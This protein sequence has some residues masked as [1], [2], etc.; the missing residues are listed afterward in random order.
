[1]PRKASVFDHFSA[2]TPS[3][4]VGNCQAKCHHCQAVIAGSVQATSNF[5]RHLMRKHPT[6]FQRLD[7]PT[8]RSPAEAID[9]ERAST[10]SFLATVSRSPKWKACDHRQE[11][12]TRSIVSLIAE[13][14]LPL[15]FAES[16]KFVELMDKAESR[17]SVPSGRAL[18]KFVPQCAAKISSDMR[19]RLQHVESL[20]L[21]L[22]V[23]SSR[24]AHSFVAITG[25]FVLDYTLMGVMLGIRRKRGTYNMEDIFQMY[26]AT[27]SRYRLTGKVA[28]IITDNLNNLME[29]FSL[30]GWGHLQEEEYLQ[31]EADD[32]VFS[33]PPTNKLDFIPTHKT[34][35]YA[36]S[37]QLVVQDGLSA[38][39]DSFRDVISQASDL[40]IFCR[41]SG[42]LAECTEGM[43]ETQ[44]KRNVW[45][46]QLRLLR[47]VVSLPHETLIRFGAPV[48]FSSSDLKL[49]E[50]LCTI[51]E[52]FEEVFEKIQNVKAVTASFVL[53]CTKGL[54]TSL[55]ELE[56]TFNNKLV[57]N[58]QLS[59]EERLS[60]Y[61]EIEYFQLAAM[62]DPRFKADWCQEGKV[63]EMKNLL[64]TA[65]SAISS[66]FPAPPTSTC[67]QP[68][69]PPTKR[70][71]LFAFMSSR[72][73][74]QRPPSTNDS[75]TS[76]G[77]PAKAE[78]S[79]YFE[80]PCLPED[81]NPLAYWRRKAGV[82]P[83]LARLAHKYLAAPAGS[84]PVEGLLGVA[85][86]A[87]GP[88]WGHLTEASFED[89]MLIR[90]NE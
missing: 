6:I 29:A 49:I 52:P 83:L 38:V 82:S 2:P 16:P 90:C 23:W 35:C 18:G 74:H 77:S 44:T 24:P 73:G 8:P 39:A 47:L 72:P 33:L 50:E 86:R 1:M 43:T 28:L 78:V 57:T 34:S 19:A 51:L 67:V 81:A 30:P 61:E 75:S 60:P 40:V 84:T 32:L 26:Q 59:L 71:R 53:V 87:W 65:V 89:L 62:L 13:N 79:H 20:C 11:A 10:T 25:H 88:G 66:A 7:T 27:T 15:D 42:L 22:D 31:T 58:L 48:A 55:S 63:H 17:Y 80:E 54:R 4:T 70:S 14:L 68:S 21:T 64:L 76:F 9:N 69:P 41:N 37:L 12:I 85:G 3:G 56:A 45:N 46:N 36:H 5:R